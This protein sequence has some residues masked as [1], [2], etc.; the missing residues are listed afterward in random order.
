[1]IETE[2]VKLIRYITQ[3][4]GLGRREVMG[5]IREERVRVNGRV[6]GSASRQIA[7]GRDRVQMDGKTVGNRPPLHLV[8]Y[9]PRASVCTRSDPEGRATIYELVAPRHRRAVSVGRLDYHTTGVL[10]M[11]TDGELARRLTLPRYGVDRVYRVRLRGRVS[12]SALERWRAGLRVGGRLTRPAR[13]RR[14]RDTAHGAVL[15]V[16]LTEGRNRQIHE[17]AR[18]T[19]LMAAKIHRVRFAGVTLKGLRPGGYR[20]LA[21]AEVE[22]LMKL[23]GLAP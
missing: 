1:V 21:S 16:T 17:M 10:L 18:A 19:G 2:A 13:V 14:I 6:E 8:V 20:V 7:P 3:S 15:M 11:T 12:E 23:V 9:K 4:T 22:R 5:A